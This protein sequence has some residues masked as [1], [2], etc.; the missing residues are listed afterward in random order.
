MVADNYLK[1]EVPLDGLWSDWAYM[2]NFK[3]FT[4]NSDFTDVNATLDKWN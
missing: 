1:Y 3:D 2:D 4:L